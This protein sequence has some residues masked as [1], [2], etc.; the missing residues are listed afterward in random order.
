MQ[1]THKLIT[2]KSGIS[3]THA[4][5]KRHFVRFSAPTFRIFLS[6]Q[7]EGLRHRPYRVRERGVSKCTVLVNTTDWVRPRSIQYDQPQHHWQG[8][9]KR[10]S[11]F[12]SS[13]YKC[14]HHAL[15]NALAKE[16]GKM[17]VCFVFVFF[18]FTDNTSR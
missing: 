8:N 6:R 2:I 15:V 18:C 9:K 16:K 11:V 7:S 13:K 1:F 4:S 10:T 14:H 12:S 5:Q 3:V 17:C